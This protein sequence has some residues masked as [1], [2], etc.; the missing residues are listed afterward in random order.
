MTTKKEIDSIHQLDLDDALMESEIQPSN[1]YQKLDRQQ[2]SW[3]LMQL[4]HSLT[5][6]GRSLLADIPNQRKSA[7]TLSIPGIRTILYEAEV[8]LKPTSIDI[9]KWNKKV[10]SSLEMVRILRDIYDP[11][12]LLKNEFFYIVYLNRA[13]EII[14]MEKHS[15]GG[16]SGTIACIKSMMRSTAMI[17]ASGIILSH[18]HPSGNT[19]PSESDLQ[20][21]RK[22]KEAMKLI[23]VSLLDHV[24]ITPTG[25]LS[26][27]DEG[28]L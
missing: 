8:L 18:N 15:H 13:S 6:Y 25:F 21:T 2:C 16:V 26:F 10:G 20:L 17:G 4:S 5:S 14:A 19:T 11:N 28:I 3:E 1:T 27:T 12:Y 24:I 9:I 23:E 7:R 22:V